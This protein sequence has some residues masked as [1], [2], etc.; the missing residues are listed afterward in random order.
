[1]SSNGERPEPELDDTRTY[2]YA[3]VEYT[4]AGEERRFRRML[5]SR[6]IM[7]RNSRTL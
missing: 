1:M 3:D 2:R 7:L 5:L 6:T 4:P